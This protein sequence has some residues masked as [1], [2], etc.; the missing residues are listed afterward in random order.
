[1]Y[2]I[3]TDE[4]FDPRNGLFKVSTTG[5]GVEPSPF[6]AAIPYSEK[7]YE[8]AGILLAKSIVDK[9]NVN[10]MLTGLF[11]KQILGK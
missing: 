8:Y 9:V 5:E 2:S 7:L 10:V 6:A 11:L 4:I 3:A 1:L